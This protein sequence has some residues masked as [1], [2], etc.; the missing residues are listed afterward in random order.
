M[1]CGSAYPVSLTAST[2][3]AETRRVKEG[4]T[5][6]KR[7]RPARRGGVPAAF[8]VL[9][10]ASVSSAARA[11]DGTDSPVEVHG[12]V[13]QG[14]IKTTENNYLA[15]DSTRGSFE[16]TEAGINF[17]KPLT[18][19]LRAGIQLF[20]HDLGPL[21]NYSPQFD[22]FYLD[23]RFWDWLG[24][25]AGRTK[26]PFGLYNET[27]D[28]DAARV[29]VLLP[30]SLY[31][32]QNREF[33]LAQTGGEIYGIVPLGEAGE[34]E[35][36]GYGGTIFL[37]TSNSLTEL[38]E[39]QV[40]YLVGGRLMWL[41]PLEGLQ[42]GGSVQALRLDFDFQPSA[43]QVAEFEAA[44][45]LPPDFSGTVS[46]R[47]PALLWIASLE[48]QLGELSLAAE[49]GRSYAK[50]E[51]SLLLPETRSTTEGF[52]GLATYRV[53]PW[54]TPGIYYSVLNP[55]LGQRT[56]RSAYQR[57]LALTFRYDLNAHWLLKLE[58]HYM[59]GT[60]ALRADLNDGAPLNTLAKRWGVLLI[61]TTAYF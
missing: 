52:Y 61:K 54:F 31:P 30:Q 55:S 12:F 38:S 25:R 41:A 42:L 24:I 3:Y 53:T 16:F 2:R 26:L 40:P 29:P 57:D 60:A 5:T 14:F 44:G 33:L 10:L 18:D 56:G 35:Y 9:A 47:I 50:A 51:T 59:R 8:M 32:V 21:G 46:A 7:I 15:A 39:F 43:E 11:E 6:E 49:Y 22:W 34:A 20:A 45:Q 27:N 23:Y 37:D 1:V 19:K 48:Y 28:I 13:S 4:A 58:G 17:T 36:R